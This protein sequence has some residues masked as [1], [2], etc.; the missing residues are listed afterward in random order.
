M[1][2][3]TYSADQ[4]R[5][6]LPRNWL[7]IEGQRT[8]S[9]RNPRLEGAALGVIG[10]GGA[11]PTFAALVVTAGLTF[12][13]VGIGTEGGLPYFDLRISGTPNVTTAV[14]INP[15][16]PPAPTDGQVWTYSQFSRLVGGSLTNVGDAILAFSLG[17]V[18]GSVNYTLTNA[19]LRT[20]RQS[21]TALLIG[22]GSALLRW[23]LNVT[24]NQPVDLTIRFGPWQYGQ[25]AEASTPIFPPVNAPAVATR[26]ADLVTATMSTLF[27][28]GSGTL[29]MTADI[30]TECPQARLRRT[31]VQADAG[32]EP[33]AWALVNEPARTN[34]IRNPLGEGGTTGVLGSGGVLPTNYSFTS[35]AGVSF[36]F[37]G[38]F[39]V[40][41]VRCMRYR[42]FGTATAAAA[43][44]LL[45]EGPT[46]VAAAV[47]QFWTQTVHA[48]LFA[49][50]GSVPTFQVRPI[51][52][53]SAGTQLT[54]FTGSTAAITGTLTAFTFTAPVVDATV[55]FVQ[56]GIAFPI[57]NGTAY[58]CTFDIGG[59][60][61]EQGVNRSSL[62]LPPVGTPGA[63]SR[64]ANT[65]TLVA[66]HQA[67]GLGTFMPGTP[68]KA[69]VSFSATAVRGLMDGGAAVSLSVLAQ[70]TTLRIGTGIAAGTG[71]FATVGGVMTSPSE[72][73]DP[74]LQAAFA[75]LPT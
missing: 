63:T 59:H 6:V 26:S 10:S 23:R 37:I 32:S 29:T 62:L 50:P 35:V 47:N 66:G 69:G 46:V 65:I 73:A 11:L 19:P 75:L 28:V 71:L 51:S 58:D 70:P 33:P 20:N 7:L 40:D 3:V 53:N 42:V 18:N 16:T 14:Q 34:G 56:P 15:D 54:A 52:R 2:W 12:E 67:R 48:R 27:P 5:Y 4:P 49:S 38:I 55:A 17:N 72:A 41:G 68:L 30:P 13:V 36:E 39:D 9:F 24:L 74:E 43:A 60:Q 1:T 57:V 22:G 8:N 25:G 21:A 61:L 45:P 31:L 44:F 64:P